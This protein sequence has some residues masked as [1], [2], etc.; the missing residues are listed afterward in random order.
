MLDLK[1]PLLGPL[2]VGGEIGCGSSS[3]SADLSK[4]PG[5]TMMDTSFVSLSPNHTSIAVERLLA[6]WGSNGRTTII[7]HA[8]FFCIRSKLMGTV[9]AD[10]T[11]IAIFCIGSLADRELLSRNVLDLLRTG[12]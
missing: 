8:S 2:P 11:D 4:L 3:P 7:N 12:E 10:Y 6:A 9:I 1:I 5:T